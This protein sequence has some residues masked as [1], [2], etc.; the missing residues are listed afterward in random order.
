MVGHK[1]KVAHRRAG[2]TSWNASE[3]AQR[4]HLVKQLRELADE[5][6]VQADGDTAASNA[7]PPAAPTDGHGTRLTAAQ[8]RSGHRSARS[9]RARPQPRARHRARAH[10]NASR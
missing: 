3:Q 6:E 10:K 8:T 9:T 5:L 1:I 7:E 4:K 2:Q